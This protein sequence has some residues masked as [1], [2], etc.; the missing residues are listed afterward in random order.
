MSSSSQLPI[1]SLLVIMRPAK[2][3]NWYP[4]LWDNNPILL[5]FR[6]HSNWG[7]NRGWR[8]KLRAKDR[9]TLGI[10]LKSNI[11]TISWHAFFLSGSMGRKW[12]ILECSFFLVFWGA[13]SNKTICVDECS[14]ITAFFRQLLFELVE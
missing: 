2:L 10:T 6:I 12:I 7:W 5:V 11:C 13:A 14:R 9:V 4:I 8:V 3:L 1:S